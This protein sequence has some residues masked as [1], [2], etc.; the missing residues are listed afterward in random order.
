MSDASPASQNIS[1]TPSIGAPFAAVPVP[2]A[3]DDLATLHALREEL[4][5]KT[6][7]L[8]KAKDDLD[9]N[10]E[11]SLKLCY[12]LI[13]AFDPLLGDQACMVVKIC[14]KMAESKYFT[15]PE[16]R[17]FIAAGWLHD[18]GLLGFDHSVL[19]K[20]RS[21]PASLS[22]AELKILRHH[23]I[24]GQGLA[25]FVSK[26]KG[27]GETIRSHHERFDGL[28]YP[29][30]YTGETIPWTARCLAVAAYFVECGLPKTLALSS[31]LEQSG[32]AFDPEAV[33]LFFKMTQSADLPQQI[34]E[35]MVDELTPGMILS[36]GIFNDVGMLLVPEGQPLT[37]ATIAKIKNY[38]MLT[39]VTERLLI[40]N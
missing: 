39:S 6:A 38:N 27:I 1:G 2:V 37:A 13:N 19:H 32:S 9:A 15:A 4:A 22:T 10:F 40:F 8:E 35:V 21:A 18:I 30:G 25:S 36:K 26:L 12:R 34:R 20:M 17:A 33:R 3:A 24:S 7:E 23:P 14:T 28:G 16:K 11:N 5:A 29:D 31:I